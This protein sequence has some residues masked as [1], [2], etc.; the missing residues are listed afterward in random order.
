MSSR[1]IMTSRRGAPGARPHRPRDRR[2][3]R[4][5]ERPG[6]GRASSDAASR[7]RSGI[8]EA[9]EANEGVRL[10]VGTPRHHL[11][12]RRP[13]LADRP[14][15][16]LEGTS[17]PFD[18]AATTIVDRGRRAVHGPNH[19]RRHGRAGRTGPARGRPARGAGRPGPPGAAHPRRPRGQ[20]RAHVRERRGRPGDGVEEVDER[21]DEV[22]HRA[23]RGG[24]RGPRQP[25]SASVGMPWPP[26]TAAPATAASA[27]C[28]GT[29]S[30]STCCAGTS[31]PSS[32]TSPTGWPTRV[33]APGERRDLAG[34]DR[35]DPV[36]RG[37]APAPASRS[38]SPRGRWVATPCPSTRSRARSPRA[39]RSSTPCARWRRWA[40]RCW[41]CAMPGAAPRSSPPTHFGGHV[42]NAGDGWHAHP[43]QALLDL[44]TLRQALGAE[45]LAEAKVC[46]VGDVLHSRVARSNIWSLTALG[47]RPV[48]DRPGG[49][50]ARLRDLGART[51][52]RPAADRD[53]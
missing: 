35:R 44:F 53:R 27:V 10:P 31:W 47:R 25:R 45:R 33:A 9:I 49:V 39:S 28:I 11:P 24:R 46:I 2:E 12:P 29:C 15:R 14:A 41:S 38:S 17:L 20:E 40:P 51:A 19:P 52:R 18:P 36:R 13:A 50:P 6:A 42:V 30:T 7:W 37:V 22:A 1:Q 16:E 21:R 32:W 48:A 8:A 43:T 34:S 3:A 26:S 5:H 23:A 4:R